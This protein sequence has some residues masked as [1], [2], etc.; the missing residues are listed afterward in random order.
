MSS[1]NDI[2]WA[3]S[4]TGDGGIEFDLL[5]KYKYPFDIRFKNLANARSDLVFLYEGQ[6]VSLQ[7]IKEIYDELKRNY[8]KIQ[9][10]RLNIQENFKNK[11][12]Q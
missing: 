10:K 2:K 1:E 3:I 5:C 7:Y 4:N 8:K 6:E 12:F 11:E 9:R